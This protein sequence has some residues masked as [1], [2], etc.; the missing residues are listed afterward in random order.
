[1]ISKFQK[2]L[3]SENYSLFIIYFKSNL[4]K[5]VLLPNEMLFIVMG[6]WQ[7]PPRGG[8]GI[9]LNHIFGLQRLSFIFHLH[10]AYCFYFIVDY[11][12]CR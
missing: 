5:Y 9:R 1:M 4:S 10:F 11:P 12:G 6:L 7:S 3:S 2:I 8:P